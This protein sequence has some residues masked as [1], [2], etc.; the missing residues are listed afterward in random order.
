MRSDSAEIESHVT[1]VVIRRIKPDCVD[2]YK[3]WC[4]RIYNALAIQP[5][6]LR[7]H[8]YEPLG[9]DLMWTHV[10]HFTTKEAAKIWMESDTAHALWAEVH[11]WCVEENIGML[12]LDP[13]AAILGM[14]HPGAAPGAAKPVACSLEAGSR[15]LSCC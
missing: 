6:F 4:V 14:T 12:E 8:I 1:Q 7:K 3:Q 13:T 5:G 10:L 9:E 2:H 15:P 11:P